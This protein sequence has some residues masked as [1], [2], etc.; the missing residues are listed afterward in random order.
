[1]ASLPNKNNQSLLQAIEE[2]VSRFRDKVAI[3]CPIAGDVTFAQ[4]A[5]MSDVIARE[6]HASG[7]AKGHRVVIFA[8]RSAAVIVSMHAAVSLGAT[9][10]PVAHN[11]PDHRLKGVIQDC[12][13]TL[14]ICDSH[15]IDMAQ[16]YGLS[17]NIPI[18]ELEVGEGVIAPTDP[19]SASDKIP[20]SEASGDSAFYILYTSGSTGHPKGV[21]V[22]HE[23][24]SDYVG[25][26][27]DYFGVTENDTILSTAPFY[28]DMSTF[29]IYVALASGAELV[30]AS[31][32]DCVFPKLLLGKIAAKNIT[33]WK[34][35]SSLF[36]HV[37][38]IST[39]STTPL[40]SL[41]ILVFSGERLPTRYLVDW[42]NTVP[43]ACYYNAYGPTEATG[44]S[45]CY[46]ID[47]IPNFDEVIPIGKPC[48]KKEI[49]LFRDDEPVCA[50][51]EPGEIVIGGAGIA[52]GYWRDDAKTSRS[53]VVRIGSTTFDNP[54]YKTGDLGYVN[55]NGNHV[56]LSRMD[57]QV[58]HQGYRIELDDVETALRNIESISDAAVICKVDRQ[59]TELVAFYECDSSIDQSEVRATLMSRL[60]V[61]MIPKLLKNVSA[62]PRSERGKIDYNALKSMQD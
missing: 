39:F 20:D 2:T 60:P 4:F 5:A 30:I 24:V 40:P 10:I 26:A 41:R 45:T 27:I 31:D 28:F 47:G 8:R 16:A 29:D 32:R 13:P 46:R 21:I 53:F 57:R 6:L 50:R 59:L 33:V 62:L 51:N 15:T 25:W 52:K 34:A 14:L 9:Y 18:L 38:K 61:Y 22:T 56:F 49:M 36:A 35:V 58:K 3:N 43:E 7:V 11:M 48:T 17:R 23:N 44:I 19:V 1:M 37:A 12:E 54:V 55:E 42:M